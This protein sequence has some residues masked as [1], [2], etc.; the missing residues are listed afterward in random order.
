MRQKDRL[1][2]ILFLAAICLFFTF[3]IYEDMEAGFGL[4]HVIGE[5]AIVCWAIYHFVKQWRHL[6]EAKEET[7]QLRHDLSKARQDFQLYQNETKHYAQGLSVKIDE[8]LEKWHLSNA[9]KD[10]C[11]LLLKG[12]SNKEI[13]DMRT[14][15][16]KTV[17]QQVSAILQKANLHSRSELIAFFLEDILVL[18]PSV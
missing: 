12:L 1:V 4:E 2:G 17:R 18:S 15:S 7:S 9:E 11:L 16:E 13:A 3:D 14:T 6:V 10:I 8:Q 5:V